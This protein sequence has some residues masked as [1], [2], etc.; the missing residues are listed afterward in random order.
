V[1]GVN[2]RGVTV[3]WSFIIAPTV[4]SYQEEELQYGPNSTGREVFKF[5]KEERA[6]FVDQ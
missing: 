5:K 6:F 1:G 4:G 3:Q 2:K